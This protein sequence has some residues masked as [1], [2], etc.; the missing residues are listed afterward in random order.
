MKNLKIP[1]IED[2]W[3]STIKNYKG[4]KHKSTV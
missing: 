4:D 3:K 1:E 2:I